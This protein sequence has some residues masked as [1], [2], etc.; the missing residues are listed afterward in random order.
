M[1]PNAVRSGEQC[2][3]FVVKLLCRVPTCNWRTTGLLKSSG[4]V[5]VPSVTK[6]PP[7][8][9]SSRILRSRSWALRTRSFSSLRASLSA[10]VSRR[11]SSAGSR[12][13]FPLPMPKNDKSCLLPRPLREVYTLLCDRS[14]WGVSVGPD[15]VGEVGLRCLVERV[16]PCE[17]PGCDSF[18][19]LFPMLLQVCVKLRVKWRL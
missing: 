15:V 4:P 9:P 10:L 19:W 18:A 14:R 11:G 7:S 5:Y 13:A 16:C 12:S 2:E 17:D 6:K 8:T 3:R 1:A